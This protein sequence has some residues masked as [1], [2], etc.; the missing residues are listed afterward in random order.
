M[1]SR[2]GNQIYFEG[3]GRHRIKK[4]KELK[5]LK[6]CKILR[7]KIGGGTAGEIKSVSDIKRLCVY[8]QIDMTEI[9]AKNNLKKYR[10][11]ETLKSYK[12][13][14]HDK[15]K[16][17]IIG[18][19]SNVKDNFVTKEEISIKYNVKEH[20]VEEIFK[21]LNRE[22]ILSQRHAHYAHDTNRNYI[23]SGSESGW[24]CDMYYISRKKLM[25]RL[26]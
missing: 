25:E 7:A 14:P 15:L 12:K 22:G 19:L 10:P 3:K 18:Y 8:G 13:I 26:V 21:E 17:I 11:K 6:K 5:T 9:Q 4:N 16:A 1:L 24:S 20:F 23:F 2:Y